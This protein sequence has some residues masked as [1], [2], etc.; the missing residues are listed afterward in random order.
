M[1]VTI[2]QNPLKP[3]IFRTVDASWLDIR[4]SSGTCVF[5]I[6]WPPGKMDFIT[7]NRNDPSFLPTLKEFKINLVEPP[8]GFPELPG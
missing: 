2:R 1:E 8:G 3:P 5:L 6:I 4:D 7:I